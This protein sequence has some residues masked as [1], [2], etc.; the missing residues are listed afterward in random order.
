MDIC[1][2]ILKWIWPLAFLV[3]ILISGS[4]AYYWAKGRFISQEK[5]E[6][7][8][9]GM[10]MLFLRLTVAS[11]V[12]YGV[13][14]L[15]LFILNSSIPSVSSMGAVGDFVGGVIGT[16]VTCMGAVY[17]VKTYI[18]QQ[19]QTALQ[20]FEK[21]CVTMLDFHKENVQE[22]EYIEDDNSF[23]GRN[24]FPKYV[25]I[26]K[27]IFNEVEKAIGTVVSADEE[28]YARWK[29]NTEQAK[30]AH[31]LSYG[32]FFYSV[33]DYQLE[34]KK[35]AI[36]KDLCDAVR[37]EVDKYMTDNKEVQAHI[38]LGHYY[39]HLYNMIK[40][41]DEVEHIGSKHKENYSQII[42]ALLSDY[43]QVLLYYNSMSQLGKPW[44]QSLGTED[45][46]KMCF[47]AK[48]RLLKNCPNAVPFFGILP[49]DTY[50]VEIDGYSKEGERFFDYIQTQLK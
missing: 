13:I 2:H 17:I 1:E 27:A 21:N 33:R 29:D 19:E 49:K 9:D 15:M 40:Y 24:A 23:K 48:Y 5:S 45:K 18:R 46:K 43:E 20:T 8:F 39:R 44:N 31:E 36:K 3:V 14:L 30:L 12:A 22:I 28:K 16:L 7:L 32:Y 11:A 47:M 50:K 6:S 38:Q 10:F 35:D 37:D 4:I 26:L 34:T 41:I 25:K 42:R